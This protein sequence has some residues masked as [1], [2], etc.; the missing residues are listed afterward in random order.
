MPIKLSM[1]SSWE[2]EF[3][4]LF[5]MSHWTRLE[6]SHFNLQHSSGCCI[7]SHPWI[8]TMSRSICGV[9]CPGFGRRGAARNLLRLDS[10]DYRFGEWLHFQ[11]IHSHPSRVSLIA[12]NSKLGWLLIDTIF[13]V[14]FHARR[15]R[16]EQIRKR[17]LEIG[18]HLVCHERSVTPG[19]GFCDIVTQFCDSQNPCR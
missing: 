5:V 9:F 10:T 17:I 18:M 8:H 11:F 3:C 2:L 4:G 15:C 19:S 1:A 12:D 7:L 16:F 13:A 14:H 6:P